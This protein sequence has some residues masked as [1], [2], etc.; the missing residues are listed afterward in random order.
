MH[1]LNTYS[2]HNRVAIAGKLQGAHPAE[3]RVVQVCNCLRGVDG[4][5]DGF[6]TRVEQSVLPCVGHRPRDGKPADERPEDGDSA[7]SRSRA[8][9]TQLI[10]LLIAP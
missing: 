9:D 5:V 8:A 10:M 4:H 2:G 6:V 3:M 7:S 1:I